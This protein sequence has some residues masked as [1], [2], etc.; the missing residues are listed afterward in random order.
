MPP[1]AVTHITS[2][3]QTVNAPTLL[4]FEDDVVLAPGFVAQLEAVLADLPADW[5]LVSVSL[6]PPG[7]ACASRAYRRVWVCVCCMARRRAKRW[8]AGLLAAFLALGLEPVCRG[9]VP[10]RAERLSV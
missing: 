2:L 6:V 10:S 7:P 3:E 5:D 1:S 9:L 8:E 4:V